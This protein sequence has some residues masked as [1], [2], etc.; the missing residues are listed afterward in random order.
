MYEAELSKISTARNELYVLDTQVIVLIAL[1]VLS[2]VFLPVLSP[3]FGFLSFVYLYLNL[4]KV[5]RMPCPQCAIAFGTSSLVVHG[6][7]ADRCENCGLW[8]N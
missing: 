7:G 3:V 6:L 5:A 8:L 2:I 1:V 4:V